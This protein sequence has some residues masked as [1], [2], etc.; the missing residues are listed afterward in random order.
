ML[1]LIKT[2]LYNIETGFSNFWD[3]LD[4]YT[5]AII[6]TISLITAFLFLLFLATYHFL[7]FIIVIA[8]IVYFLILSALN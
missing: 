3:S 2:I 5:K 1:E 6:I 8:I 4:R 7:L